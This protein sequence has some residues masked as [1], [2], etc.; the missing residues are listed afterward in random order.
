VNSDSQTYKPITATPVAPVLPAPVAVKAPVAPV[1]PTA[2]EGGI[3]DSG[4]VY[5]VLKGD[6]PWKIAKH[7]KVPYS[8]LVAL[9]KIDPQHLQIGQKLKIPA[10]TK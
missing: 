10:A 4:K 8:D 5:V 3:K 2:V 1:A 9:N 7:L 6:N